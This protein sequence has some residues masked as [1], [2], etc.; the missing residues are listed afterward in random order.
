VI[1]HHLG[2]TL[3][4]IHLYGSAL[5]GGLKPHSDVD[6]LVTLSARMDDSVRPHLL[7]DL[8][9]VSAPPGEDSSLRALE[10]TVVALGEVVPWRY[11]ARRELQFG[12]WLRKDIEAGVFDRSTMDMDL[13][14]LLKKARMSSIALVGPPAEE[15][16]DPIPEEDFFRVLAETPEQWREPVDWQGD[17]RNIVLTLARIWYSVATGKIVSKDAAASWALERLPAEYRPVLETARQAYLC[18]DDKDL[19]ALA[20]QVGAF[21]A[22]AKSAIAKANA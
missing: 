21:I 16:F 2:A 13:T 12:E 14:I 11:P 8:L 19:A 18:G 15:V 7:R 20:G 5:D 3:H 4:A 9:M 10:V 6:L 17:E 22:F 1:Q